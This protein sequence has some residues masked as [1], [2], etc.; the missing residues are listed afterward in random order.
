M[1]LKLQYK[2]MINIFNVNNIERKTSN[3]IRIIL[4]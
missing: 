3:L 4:R 2:L 1:K